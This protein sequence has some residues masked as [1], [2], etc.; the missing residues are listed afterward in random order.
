MFVAI[1]S[2]YSFYEVYQYGYNKGYGEGLSW[3]EGYW[4]GFQKGYIEGYAE[5]CWEVYWAMSKPLSSMPAFN[6]SDVVFMLGTLPEKYSA[7]VYR[8]Y[9]TT[10]I[11]AWGGGP[12]F[13]DEVDSWRKRIQDIN[14]LG[15]R[16]ACQLWMD[17]A[18]A[19]YLAKV[20]DLQS[21]VCVD[22]EGNPIIMPWMPQ[23]YEG[24]P[25]Y[26]CCTNNPRYR[27]YLRSQ[28]ILA[29]MAGADALFIDD[30]AG[31]AHKALLSQCGGCFCDYCVAGFREYLKNK[32]TAAE[33]RELGIEDIEGFDYR[34]MVRKVASTRSAFIEAYRQGWIPLIEEYQAYQVMSIRILERELIELAREVRGTPI[35]VGV[36]AYNL[37]PEQIFDSD[38]VDYFAA[39]IDHY[40]SQGRIPS[41]LVF[42]YKLADALGKPLASTAHGSDWAYIKEK[43]LTGLVKQWIAFA[44]A[45]G[46][47]FMVPHHIPWCFVKVGG[48]T[49]WEPYDCPTEE[50]APLY[51]FVRQNADLFDGYEAVEQVGV[52]YS[53]LAFRRGVQN[54]RDVCWSL[55]NASMP[56][57]LAAAGDEWLVNRL[58]EDELSR[59]ELIVVP[60][61]AMLEGEQQRLIEEWMAKGRAVSWTSINDLLQR[62]E[63]LA[64]LE[65]AGKVWILPRR[66]PNNPEAPVVVHLINWDYDA[67]K[68]K[69][70][71][72]DNIAI[73]L[74]HKLLGGREA[75][76][77]TLLSPDSDPIQL[78][79]ENR[80]DGVHVTVPEVTL[81]S[82][83]KIEC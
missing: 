68:D 36:N 28:V 19:Y 32:Y 83:L 7:D 73:C 61:P 54:A 78:P 23:V 38:F 10:V 34:E 2:C 47:H 3:N 18:G 24:V 66:N 31:N 52:L 70:N 67:S 74:S 82:I 5:G 62:V 25:T 75:R 79:F 56:F 13:A 69:M 51:I 22:I 12:R 33:L 11:G 27:E 16:Y 21:A 35:P 4:Q 9:G 53:N 71:R 15:I 55:L 44:Y 37:A 77:V 39:E 41:S 30:H 76:S 17:S 40:A 50:I 8:A 49:T 65:G 6:R 29:M 72:Q 42:V 26:W 46:H 43:N 81:W 45:L 57:G 48:K 60:E 20:P 59:F 58:S 63:P 14:A 1:L 64:S 80:P